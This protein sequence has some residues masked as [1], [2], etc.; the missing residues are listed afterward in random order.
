ILAAFSDEPTL[1]AE[2]VVERFVG[3]D[4]VVTRLQGSVRGG[5]FVLH[6]PWGVGRTSWVMQLVSRLPAATRIVRFEPSK[7]LTTV[8]Q[9]CEEW[10]S[11]LDTPE[12]PTCPDEIAA[13]LLKREADVVI[14]DGAELLFLRTIGGYGAIEALASIVADTREHI[15]WL[16]TCASPAFSYL[17]RTMAF[18]QNFDQVIALPRWSEGEIRS[19]VQRRQEASGIAAN[20]DDLLVHEGA[21]ERRL[22]QVV[23][24]EEGY[25]R[26]LWNF[27]EGNPRVAQLFWLRSLYPDPQGRMRVRLYTAPTADDLEWLSEQE[28]F[29]LAAF[30]LHGPLSINALALACRQPPPRVRAHVD[31]G[32][33]KGLYVRSSLQD[34]SYLI[35]L[36]HWQAAQVALR[37][38]NLLH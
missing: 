21:G 9:L 8:Q 36:E 23:E 30:H 13:A 35:S 27:A 3:A 17:C 32:V 29:L 25:I 16:M 1:E 24:T 10:Q 22:T 12:A 37:R 2:R 20:F 4:D 14:L 6:G 33:A 34:E 19:L 31:R 5:A 15:L 7:R 18:E 26:L 38:K 11:V 28:K